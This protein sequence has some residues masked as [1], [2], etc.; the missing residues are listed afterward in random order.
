MLYDCSGMQKIFGLEANVPHVVHRW[1]ADIFQYP[2]LIWHRPARIMWEYDMLALY[3]K[4]TESCRENGIYDLST[5]VSLAAHSVLV[6]EG[7][8]HMP[9]VLS[10]KDILDVEKPILVVNIT[11]LNFSGGTTKQGRTGNIQGAC[12]PYR[13]VVVVTS[14]VITVEEAFMDIVI[15]SRRAVIHL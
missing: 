15:N 5:E 10:T 14:V 6:K 2:L 9:V 1:R 7:A 8:Y 12:D 3:N 11:P 13:S 4:A